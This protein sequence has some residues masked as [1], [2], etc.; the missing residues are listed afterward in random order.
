MKN[1]VWYDFIAVE[2]NIGAGK[3]TLARRLSES[4]GA[5]L[6][7]ERFEDNPFLPKFYEDPA[8]YAFP[9]E[10][11][12]LEDRYRQ[13]SEEIAA[14]KKI[15]ADYYYAKSLVFARI[16]L[17]GEELVL[18]ERFFGHLEKR[19][20]MPGLVIYLHRDTAALRQ[21]IQN[22]GRSYEQ[23][24]EDGYL[25]KIGEGYRQHFHGKMPFPVLLIDTST[26]DADSL[27]ELASETVRKRFPNGLTEIS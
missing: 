7:T 17:A 6:V 1:P 20:R 14:D 10:L 23:G 15:V 27:F 9:L 18:F 3:T 13:L 22:R 26:H 12:F 25:Q 16:N 19:M 11:S 5:E 24:I 8:T 21:N 2:G 4:A